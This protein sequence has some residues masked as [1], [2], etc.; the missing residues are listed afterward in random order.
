MYPK[1]NTHFRNDLITIPAKKIDV[2]KIVDNIK[3]E[4]KK[5]KI[6]YIQDLESRLPNVINTT[7][8]EEFLLDGWYENEIIARQRARWT[9]KEF[10]FLFNSGDSSTINLNI[11]VIP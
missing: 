5:K 11:R 6:K 3:S 7:E 4:I 1:K 8:N 9:K 2:Q 10:S